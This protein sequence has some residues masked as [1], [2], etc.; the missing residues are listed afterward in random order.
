[1]S[2]EEPEIV[3]VA[4][5]A[6]ELTTHQRILASSVGALLTSLTMTPFDVVKVRLQGQRRVSNLPVNCSHYRLH[7]GL[8]DV[9]CRK[10][11]LPQGLKFHGPIDAVVKMVRH[12]GPTSLWR[13]LGP[14][15]IMSIPSTIVY[16]NLYEALKRRYE[17]N[18]GNPHISPLYSGVTARTITTILVSPI[19]LIRTKAQAHQGRSSASVPSL[20]RSELSKQAGVLSLWRGVWPTLW[21]DVPFSAFY[22][23]LYE[24]VK[25]TLA[26]AFPAQKQDQL[27]T[28][29]LAF[30]SGAT[31][32]TISAVLTHPFDLVK[33]RRQIEMYELYE[34]P[35]EPVSSPPSSSSLAA[36]LRNDARQ[37][38]KA[39]RASVVNGGAAMLSLGGGHANREHSVLQMI[40][41]ISSSSSSSSSSCSSAS[42]ACGTA[43]AAPQ[44]QQQ[45]PKK[46]TTLNVLKTIVREE[47]WKGLGT[48]ITAR[49]AKIAPSCAIM[50]SSYEVAKLY[51][52]RRNNRSKDSY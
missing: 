24:H 19:E 7:T 17:A 18:G 26:A 20:I 15:L 34:R 49:V 22:W 3:E 48:G 35:V 47:G 27:R 32:G 51:F 33:T 5:G 43:A 46:L 38:N 50:I 16:F 25:R 6:V 1:M 29:L 40:N 30:A 4:S 39:L 42:C 2:D 9:W 28:G 44:Q 21:R 36:A 41:A 14:S 10:C 31:S 11:D 8:M 37:A 13:G 23:M 12:E 52:S 45:G